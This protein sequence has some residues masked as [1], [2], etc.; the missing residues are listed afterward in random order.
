MSV[1]S[2]K[3]F[4]DLN[5]GVIQT[6]N[7]P[8][9]KCWISLLPFSVLP[10]G[11]VHRADLRGGDEEHSV[12]RLDTKQEKRDSSPSVFRSRRAQRQ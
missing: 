8:G 3:D 5:G 11:G 12:L 6:P 4:Q 1:L 7:S 2:L 9:V 10:D